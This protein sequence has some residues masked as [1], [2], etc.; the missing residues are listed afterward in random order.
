MSRDC[1]VKVAKLELPDADEQS[2]QMTEYSVIDLCGEEESNSSF[3]KDKPN[4]VRSDGCDEEELLQRQLTNVSDEDAVENENAAMKDYT[5]DDVNSETSDDN[6][7][8]I[9]DE[10]DD[11]VTSNTNVPSLSSRGLHD[12]TEKTTT[13]D[14]Q[15]LFPCASRNSTQ[16]TNAN[17]PVVKLKRLDPAEIHRWSATTS[18]VPD[19]GHSVKMRYAIW[20]F[21]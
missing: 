13:L 2:T 8:V 14:D 4:S 6:Y 18:R 11:S 9:V 21:L 3:D 12:I 5:A 16:K 10:C 7:M 15:L 1:V 19:E 20:N 17:R